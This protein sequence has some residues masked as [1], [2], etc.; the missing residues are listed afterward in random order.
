MP[1]TKTA[2]ADLERVVHEALEQLGSQAD[3]SKIAKRV[4]RLDIGV[5]RED[6]FSVI[7]GWLGCCDLI[8]KLDQTQTPLHSGDTYQVPDLL[9]VFT[10]DG[11]KIP[12]LIEVK[13]KKDQTLSFKPDYLNKLKR[14]AEAVNLP[15]LIAWKFGPVWALFEARHLKK[16]RVNYNIRFGDAPKEN[17]LGSLAGDFAYSLH[18]GAGFHLKIAKQELLETEKTESGRVEHWKMMIEDV[19]FTDGSGNRIHKLPGPLQQLFLTWD[20]D[21]D[22]FHSHTHVIKSFFVRKESTLFAHMALVRL[23]DWQT[24]TGTDIHW[25]P[26]LRAD[27]VVKAIDNLRETVSEAMKQGFVRIALNQLP[28]TRPSYET[29]I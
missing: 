3:A 11:A 21:D 29:E 14:Y 17:L 22:E 23:L 16:A 9:A 25:R 26:L 13:S 2:P 18:E 24:P 12:V 27:S 20:L 28:Q 4:A 1:R 5:P 10:K 8:H 19:Y 6:E 7:C 15:L